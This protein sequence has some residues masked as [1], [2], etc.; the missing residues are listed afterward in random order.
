[1]SERE[2]SQGH[3]WHH[4]WVKWKLEEKTHG[5]S[6]SIKFVAFLANVPQNPYLDHL[7]SS[8]TYIHMKQNPK[9]KKQ[10][11]YSGSTKR[12]HKWNNREETHTQ[13]KGERKEC[14]K[15]SW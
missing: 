15:I 1:M 8:L 3:I 12:R 9:F 5:S 11:T 6:L 13:K 4:Q 7:Y 2:A 14:R 10:K